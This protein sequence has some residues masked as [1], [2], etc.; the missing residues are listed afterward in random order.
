MK[1]VHEIAGGPGVGGA[2]LKPSGLMLSE[3]ASRVG[4]LFMRF[5]TP[6]PS[7]PK[8][9]AL[10]LK[11]HPANQPGGMLPVPIPPFPLQ[12]WRSSGNSSGLEESRHA[13]LP[14]ALHSAGVAKSHAPFQ[15]W[16][17][18]VAAGHDV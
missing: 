18:G 15:P 11:V 12:P 5:L 14:A 3:V 16:N 7:H 2:S 1:A 9:T 17:A 13:A 10:I 4:I 6:D 8:E